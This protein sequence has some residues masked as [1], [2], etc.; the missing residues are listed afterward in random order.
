MAYPWAGVNSQTRTGRTR[1][2]ELVSTERQTPKTT[3][4]A[5][6]NGRSIGSLWPE[7]LAILLS[8]PAL[9]SASRRSLPSRHRSCVGPAFVSKQDSIRGSKPLSSESRTILRNMGS[10][11]R[12][13]A[14]P[15]RPLYMSDEGWQGKPV[16]SS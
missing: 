2:L 7:G 14:R 11:A 1:Q 8:E 6:L 4:E 5:R 9:G 12:A 10:C 15:R 13:H 3:D 16:T